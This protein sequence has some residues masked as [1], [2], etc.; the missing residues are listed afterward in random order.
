MFAAFGRMARWVAAAAGRPARRAGLAFALGAI[1]AAA[2]APVFAFP[3]LAVGFT[4]LLWLL[5]GCARAPRPARARF[6]LGWW[7]GFGYFVPGLYWIALSLLTDAARF[8]WLVPFCVLGVPAGLAL[9]PALG[10]W[11]ASSLRLRGIGRAAAFAACWVGAEWLRGTALTGF[12]WNLAGHTWSFSAAMIQPAAILGAYGLSLWTVGVAALPASWGE[13]GL[14]LR[15]RRAAAVLFVLMPLGIWG[16]GAMRL[17]GAPEPDAVPGV[18]LRL[19]QAHIAQ[20]LKWREDQRAANLRAHVELSRGPGFDAISHVVWPE[21]ATAYFLDSD[22]GARAAVA[23][24]VPPGGLLLTGALRARREP[25]QGLQVWNSFHVLDGAGRI[26]ATYDK[27]HLVP[28][29]EFVPFRGILPIAKLTAG[30]VDFSSGPGPR[31]LAVPGLPPLGPLICYEAIFPGHAVDGANRPDWLLNITNDAWFGE[32]SGPHQH[33][34]AARVRTV[35]EGLPLVRAASTGISAVVD[36]H[37]RVLARLDL[38]ARGVLDAGLPRPLENATVFA[39]FGNLAMVPA[40]AIA[41]VIALLFGRAAAP[42]GE[43]SRTAKR[44]KAPRG[45]GKKIDRIQLYV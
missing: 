18:R 14:T 20:Q 10:I 19:V 44:E 36:G 9:F 27:H 26:V 38:G 34:A 42:N 39:R 11:V 13:A 3:A 43:E 12:P 4:G 16:F 37:G 32:S 25:G 8:W 21:T 6:W 22:D 15:H 24:A 7:F 28:F 45:N 30:A 31:T 29:G 1:A 33:F 40:F 23:G 35:E 2:F 17:A 41:G 5:D